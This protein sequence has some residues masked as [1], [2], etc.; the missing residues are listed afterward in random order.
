LGAKVVKKSD[1]IIILLQKII[2][3][4]L[5]Q[6][7]DYDG[8]WVLMRLVAFKADLIVNQSPPPTSAAI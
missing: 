4:S 2:P 7:S 8:K 1:N 6:A 5:T 3:N